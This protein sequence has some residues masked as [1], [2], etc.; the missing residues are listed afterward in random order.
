[1][2]KGLHEMKN[3]ISKLGAFWLSLF[4]LC[5]EI[6]CA[7]NDFSDLLLSRSLALVKPGQV[8]IVYFPEDKAKEMRSGTYVV[9]GT[10]FAGIYSV[11]CRNE[12]TDSDGEDDAILPDVVDLMA[13]VDTYCTEAK[14]PNA[15]TP[16]LEIYG[17]ASCQKIIQPME[18][19]LSDRFLMGYTLKQEF[20][21]HP[22]MNK[23]TF[24]LKDADLDFYEP[25]SFTSEVLSDLLLGVMLKIKPCE[26]GLDA[27][28]I[29]M[30][31]PLR[32]GTRWSIVQKEL[33][34]KDVT[35]PKIFVVCPEGVLE[36]TQAS[37][38]QTTTAGRSLFFAKMQGARKAILSQYK[39]TDEKYAKSINNKDKNQ[40]RFDRDRIVCDS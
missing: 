37:G 30:N 13:L 19:T 21:Q 23:A 18:D 20:S 29:L 28:D 9:S 38:L 36:G 27:M 26:G 11:Y 6:R 7:G 35:R 39:H 5:G 15:L 25:C 17:E 16:E 31:F 22:K 2:R 10:L 14:C 1:M 3:N 32:Y 8:R 24:C 12:E 4:F 33:T 34:M 40:G